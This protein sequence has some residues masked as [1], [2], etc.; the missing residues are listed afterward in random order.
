MLCCAS[1]AQATILTFDVRFGGSFGGFA[2]YRTFAPYQPYGDNVTTTS[3]PSSGYTLNYLQGNAWTGDITAAYDVGTSTNLDIKADDQP[4][5]NW[6]QVARL[7][8]GAQGS[9]ESDRRYYY[10]FAPGPT[11][12][13]RVNS[14]DIIRFNGNGITGTNPAGQVTADWFLYQNASL[15]K[16]LSGQVTSISGTLAAS[17]SVTLGDLST[18]VANVSTGAGELSGQS[19]LLVRDT[20]NF[21]GTNR[22]LA[23]D[24]LNFD[25]LPEPGAAALLLVASLPMIFRRRTSRR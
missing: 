1:L 3:V 7:S 6:T 17:G 24:N 4:G 15:T 12:T 16:N 14:F 2:S 9:A 25:Q 10:T 19:I 22:L 5:F 8:P 11:H 21:S 20:T 23:M 13:V 18:D